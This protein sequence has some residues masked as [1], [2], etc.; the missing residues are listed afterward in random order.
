MEASVVSEQSLADVLGAR[1]RRTPMDRLVLDIVGGVLIAA[2]SI[3]ARPP[4]WFPLM[5][6]ATCFACYGCWAVTE[7]RAHTA[8]GTPGPAASPAWRFARRAAAVVGLAAYVTLLFA[9][10]GLA[11]GP[12]KS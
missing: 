12:I 6:A 11:L 7:R 4:G 8:A 2:A 9:I 10:L 1:A 3:W 5:A